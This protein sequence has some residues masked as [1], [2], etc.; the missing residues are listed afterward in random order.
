MHIGPSMDYLERAYDDSKYGRP[1]RDPILEMTMPTSVDTTIA[2]P[3]K[4]IV[5]MF[6]QY[7]PYRLAR[8]DVGRAQRKIRR[9][10]HRGV[11]RNMPPTCP[12][13]ILHRQILSPLD[14]ERTLA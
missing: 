3:G 5:S 9:S 7:A 1:S 2:P 6:V 8:G 10:V 4:H 13:A 14:L 12:A 11:S